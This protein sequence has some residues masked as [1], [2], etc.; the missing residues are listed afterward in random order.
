MKTWLILFIFVLSTATSAQTVNPAAAA[1]YNQQF[2]QMY[3][4]QQQAVMAQQAAAIKGQQRASMISLIGGLCSGL[5]A[6]RAKKVKFEAS[7]IE[8]AAY[9][10]LEKAPPDYDK[11]WNH[12][13]AS[14]IGAA[15]NSVLASGCSNYITKDGKLG[16]WGQYALTQIRLHPDSFR[17]NI[18]TD[19]KD[20]CPNYDRLSDPQKEMVWVSNLM[21]SASPESSCNP[22]AKGKGPDG[23]AL[24]LHQVW[25]NMWPDSCKNATNLLLPNQNIKCAVDRLAIELKQRKT[26]FGTTGTTY[27]GTFRSDPAPVD[28]EASRTTRA[29]IKGFPFCKSSGT[30]TASN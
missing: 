8:D 16:A 23:T 25:N 30:S 13:E 9:E 7:S 12:E 21:A 18:L 14:S 26:L 4:A 19:T 27:W 15:A 20:W 6:N 1:A 3:Q 29:L 2:M 11:T 22:N 10:Q 24:G 28:A 17:D 5:I